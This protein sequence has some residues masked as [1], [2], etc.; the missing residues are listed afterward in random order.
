M[1]HITAIAFVTPLHNHRQPDTVLRLFEGSRAAWQS[2]ACTVEARRVLIAGSLH[3]QPA[4][5]VLAALRQLGLLR[6]HPAL[7]ALVVGNPRRAEAVTLDD[8][9]ALAVYRTGAGLL[10]L[11]VTLL[12]PS[13]LTLRDVDLARSCGMSVSAAGAEIPGGAR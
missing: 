11:Q 10:R 5:A 2:E 4:Y 13:C 1:G 7:A 9:T 12:T 3:H 8:A 6:H